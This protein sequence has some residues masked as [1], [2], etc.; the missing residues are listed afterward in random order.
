MMQVCRMEISSYTV[1]ILFTWIRIIYNVSY[2]N[3]F[4]KIML[5]SKHV[6]LLTLVSSI[7]CLNATY[8][9]MRVQYYCVLL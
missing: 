7:E 9:L 8:G 3:S 6:P 4:W 5:V 2:C 1:L